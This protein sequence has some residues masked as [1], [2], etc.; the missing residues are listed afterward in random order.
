MADKN[1]IEEKEF[2]TFPGVFL[3]NNNVKQS[4]PV[5]FEKDWNTDS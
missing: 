2:G 5:I 4:L 3:Q 1:T